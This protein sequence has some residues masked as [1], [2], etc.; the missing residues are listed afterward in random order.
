MGLGVLGLEGEC[1][2]MSGGCLEGIYTV[3]GKCLE[4]VKIVFFNPISFLGV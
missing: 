4:S 3:S 2:G 1:L